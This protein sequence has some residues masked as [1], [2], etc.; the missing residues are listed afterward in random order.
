[1][2]VDLKEKIEFIT[3]EKERKNG[4]LTGNLV[5]TVVYR[6]RC[7]YL[8]VSGMEFNDSGAIW[9]QLKGSFRVRYCNFTK[10][11]NMH[12]KDYKIK[13]KGQIYNIEFATDF[14]QQHKW[15]D[16]KSTLVK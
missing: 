5:D 15:I 14:K 11:L 10:Q 4:K 1:M 12:T 6:C 2:G 13:F 9:E 7:S 8:D 16:I 3:Q